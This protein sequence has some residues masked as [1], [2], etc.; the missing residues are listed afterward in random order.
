MSILAAGTRAQGSVSYLDAGQ[1][2]A[3]V[4]FWLPV[5]TAA[6]EVAQSGF[7]AALLTALDGLALGVRVR[8]K[9]VDDTTY[10]AVPPT[11]GAAREI[12]LKMIFRDAAT[13]QTWDSILPTLDVSLI[14]YDTNYGAKDVVLFEG[15]EIVALVDALADITIKN[16]YNYAN[17]GTLVGLQVVRGFK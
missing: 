17:N 9:Y 15:T 8:D 3:S 11:N 10:P 14:T 7:W 2:R 6:N 4:R 16:P 13:G 12:G 1:E 5:I